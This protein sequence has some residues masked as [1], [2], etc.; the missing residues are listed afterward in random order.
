[1]A[2]KTGCKRGTKEIWVIPDYY[3]GNHLYGFTSRVDAM[4]FK[5]DIT[6]KFKRDDINIHLQVERVCLR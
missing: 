1:M 4:N 2:K 3:T 6:K 5:Q